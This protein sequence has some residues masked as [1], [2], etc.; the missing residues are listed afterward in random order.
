MSRHHLTARLCVYAIEC[1]AAVTLV[2]VIAFARV[3][4]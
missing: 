4:L 2:A 3:P 1:V